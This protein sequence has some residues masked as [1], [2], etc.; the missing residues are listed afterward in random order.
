[1]RRQR[2]EK[3]G[4]SDS[5]V[6]IECK[7]SG[8]ITIASIANGRSRR[9]A[10]NVAKKVNTIHKDSGASIREG[11]REEK[12]A[13]GNEIASIGYH[14][15]FAI[16]RSL[17]A[18]RFAHAGYNTHIR[19]RVARMSGATSGTFRRFIRPHP[20]AFSPSL[21]A[22]RFAHAGYKRCHHG[23]MR[24]AAEHRCGR[25]FQ[26]HHGQAEAEIEHG[27]H[28]EGVAIAHH[29]RLAMHDLR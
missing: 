9:A 4:S 11:D 8:S 14:I 19:W 29:H 20:S 21:P 25:L 15:E 17:P 16:S 23:S 28:E 7:W 2:P 3:S 24:V 6:K 12:S 13:P 22:Y 27:Q 10:R 26:H 18:C 1:M 5:N